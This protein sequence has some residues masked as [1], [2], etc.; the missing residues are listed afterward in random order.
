MYAECY[1]DLSSFSRYV[2]PKP[3]KL[4]TQKEEDKNIQ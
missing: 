2:N 4:K 3:N 1:V